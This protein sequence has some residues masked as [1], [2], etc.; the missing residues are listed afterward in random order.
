MNK[1]SNHTKNLKELK[2]TTKIPNTTFPT[3]TGAALNF[4]KSKNM[5]FLK[6]IEVLLLAG[7]PSTLIVL[8]F[9][10]L[11][12]FYLP[13]NWFELKETGT[14][15]SYGVIILSIIFYFFGLWVSFDLIKKLQ[16]SF[17]KIIAFLLIFL[18]L[19]SF[20]FFC[21]GLFIW[22]SS[23]THFVQNCGEFSIF[24]T[25]G[26]GSIYKIYYS[27][28]VQIN[29]YGNFNTCQEF[30]QNITKVENCKIKPI[31]IK[32]SVKLSPYGQIEFD[33]KNFVKVKNLKSQD[34]TELINCLEE[35]GLEVK[36]NIGNS[37]MCST[38]NAVI[39]LRGEEKLLDVTAF[40]IF[41]NP[42]VYNST[43]QKYYFAQGC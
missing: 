31:F 38:N 37:A 29:S 30:A 17:T 25:Y 13:I 36:F 18:S 4:E 43:T 32:K 11:N 3:K 39:K 24:R 10:A 21:F 40:N 42:I 26:S 20:V 35:K 5:Q 16:K 15:I 41:G 28:G 27:D 8:G 23:G 1:I 33:T 6:I 9:F 34:L 14:F 7:I 2:N 19:I 22:H 12:F